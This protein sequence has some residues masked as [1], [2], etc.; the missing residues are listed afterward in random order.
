MRKLLITGTSGFI[1]KNL[2]RIIETHYQNYYDI[3]LLNDKINEKYKTILF[4]DQ[5]HFEISDI[6]KA[7]PIDTVIILGGGVPKT[8]EQ[9]NDV[10]FNYKTFDSTFFLLNSFKDA[11]KRIVYCSSVDVYGNSNFDKLFNPSDKEIID[12]KTDVNP[13]DKYSLFKYL[14]EL[15]IKDYCEKKKIEYAILR[16]G[17]VF[18]MGDTRDNFL[19]PTWINNAREGKDLILI[20]HPDMRRNLIYV[21]DVCF[22][23]LKSIYCDKNSV[24]NVVSDNNLSLFEIA[25][26]IIAVSKKRISL[27]IKES[28]N[29]YGKNR[30]FDASK[31]QRI[32]GKERFSFDEAL[33]EILEKN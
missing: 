12:E 21:D 26:S 7:G 31:R 20:G 18:G 8:N 15:Y 29:Y 32:L 25:E 28:D 9:K 1:G 30:I 23:I 27:V 13:N 14:N 24:I 10:V 4:D 11:P 19:I 3:V 2:M 5:F 17:P 6:E 22:F 33:K 16:F